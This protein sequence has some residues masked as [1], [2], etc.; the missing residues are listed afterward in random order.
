MLY[1]HHRQQRRDDAYNEAC[2]T[3]F[4]CKTL[5]SYPAKN[6]LFLYPYLW[7]PILTF[8]MVLYLACKHVLLL[9]HSF[10]DE[11]F[12]VQKDK[13]KQQNICETLLS[14]HKASQALLPTKQR[15]T[16]FTNGVK[17]WKADL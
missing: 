5:L 2:N 6:N 14:L 7:F 16:Q 17:E 8:V 12:I 3:K 11:T 9:L 10:R 13:E 4:V 1:H 15:F